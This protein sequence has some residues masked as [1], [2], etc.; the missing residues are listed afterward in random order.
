MALLLIQRSEDWSYLFRPL[1]KIEIYFWWSISF[2]S[3]N[4]YI[5]RSLTSQHVHIE[6]IKVIL[7]AIRN[8]KKPRKLISPRRSAKA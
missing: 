7:K 4:G 2:F 3:L 5:K 6:G 8:H 1:S